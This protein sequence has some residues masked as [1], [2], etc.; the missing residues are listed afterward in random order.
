MQASVAAYFIVYIEHVH[1]HCQQI[2]I[3]ISPRWVCIFIPFFFLSVT[4]FQEEFKGLV[5]K[6]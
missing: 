6:Q 2:L 4:L 1:M 5:F 3:K